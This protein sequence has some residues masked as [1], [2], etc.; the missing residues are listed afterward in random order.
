MR[1][2]NVRILGLAGAAALLLSFGTLMQARPVAAAGPVN[3]HNYP[4][5]LGVDG[6]GSSIHGM[7]ISINER[8]RLVGMTAPAVVAASGTGPESP[9][10]LRLAKR[11][12]NWVQVSGTYCKDKSG[13][14]VF[15]AGGLSAAGLSC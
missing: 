5:V 11:N 14:D 7:H 9:T 15:V 1:L 2:L 8:A 4:H 12:R 13:G 10:M 6:A 3:A